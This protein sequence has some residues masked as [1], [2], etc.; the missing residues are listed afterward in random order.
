VP[1]LTRPITRRQS[2]DRFD[3]EGAHAPHYLVVEAVSDAWTEVLIGLGDD[4]LSPSDVAVVRETLDFRHEI[5][6]APA[7]FDVGVARIGRSSFELAIRVH[8][9]GR[10]VAEATLVL[11]QVDADRTAAVPLA[12]WQRAMLETIAVG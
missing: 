12:E 5:F 10:L 4:V 7:E 2:P 6:V 11:V 9:H 1:V 8:Q 3:R